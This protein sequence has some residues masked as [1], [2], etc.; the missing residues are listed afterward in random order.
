[1]T[2][3]S[4]ANQRATP[5]DAKE[6]K[7]PF[8]TLSSALAAGVTAIT[9][10][11]GAYKLGHDA[12]VSDGGIQFQARVNDLRDKVASAT[13]AVAISQSNEVMVRSQQRQWQDAYNKLL[14]TDKD[15][16]NENNSLNEKMKRLDPCAYMEREID[17]L[18]SSLGR[19]FSDTV[20]ANKTAAQR[21]S[22]QSQLS[23][24]RQ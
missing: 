8:T 14:D 12:G 16:V 23:T 1:M 10:I 7:A 11:G 15:L 21:D 9:L 6:K 18:N 19:M 13:T 20:D 24:C 2:G 3:L 4:A 5:T 17:T 22:I